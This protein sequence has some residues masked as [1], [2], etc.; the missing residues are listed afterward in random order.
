MSTP[1]AGVGSPVS[2]ITCRRAREIPAPAE[3]PAMMMCAGLTGRWEAVG[4]GLI[5]YISE[6]KGQ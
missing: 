6:E 2:R 1:P 5:K 4:G 3:S